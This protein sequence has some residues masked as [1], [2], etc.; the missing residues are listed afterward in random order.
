MTEDEN[1]FKEAPLPPALPNH[2]PEIL[3]HET[4]KYHLLGPSLTKAGQ[5]SVDQQ[6]VPRSFPDCLAANAAYNTLGLRSHLQC[7]ERLKIL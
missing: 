6:K 5:D 1:R 4:L 2:D 3:T 7:L